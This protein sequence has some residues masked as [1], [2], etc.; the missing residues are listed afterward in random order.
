M[1]MRIQSIFTTIAATACATAL[2][3][4]PA[5]ASGSPHFIKNLTKVT[6][7]D[8][9][10]VTVAFKE[11]GLESGSVETITV[12]AHLDA[13]YQCVNR[14]GHNPDDPK[15]TVISGDYSKSGEFKAARNGNVTGS[16][17]VT[18]PAPSTVLDCP[19]GQKAV[20]TV[21]TWS[22]ISVTDEDSLA[23]I[24]VPGTFS[25]GELVD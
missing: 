4:A 14:G 10:S 11:A 2:A 3:A 22:S 17:T 21:S 13:T 6:D 15:K 24:T 1:S 16:L 18:A 5:F 12:T 9:S 8:P 20:H 23:T 19:N 25:F 7:A